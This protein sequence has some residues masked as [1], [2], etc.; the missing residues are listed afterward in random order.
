[1]RN[2]VSV[3]RR[4]PEDFREEYLETVEAL[5]ARS[6]T[7]VKG[8]YLVESEEVRGVFQEFWEYEDRSAA[9]VHRAARGAD[10]ETSRLLERIH[11]LAPG[12]ATEVSHWR[13]RL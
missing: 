6:R 3:I 2:I 12:A 8:F 13:Q 11:Q 5:A 9:D 1:M 10:P 4:V 7:T